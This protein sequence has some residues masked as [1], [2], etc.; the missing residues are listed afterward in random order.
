MSQIDF[1]LQLW[2]LDTKI[3][4]SH[5]PAPFND[6]IKL[7]LFVFIVLIERPSGRYYIL[8]LKFLRTYAGTEGKLSHSDM[9]KA[10]GFI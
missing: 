10:S 9:L 1:S 2:L 7:H 3:N 6:N 5:D 4:K 8:A